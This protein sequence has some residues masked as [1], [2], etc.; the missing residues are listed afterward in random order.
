MKRMRI[1][2]V[3]TLS[4]GWADGP[5]KTDTKTTKSCDMMLGSGD[6]QRLPTLHIVRHDNS[7]L[8]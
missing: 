5:P 8:F 6:F 3:M 4:G 1:T 7:Y 2:Y